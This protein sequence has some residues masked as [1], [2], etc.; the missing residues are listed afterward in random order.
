VNADYLLFAYRRSDLAKNDPST[1]I[2]VEWTTDLAG[3]WTDAVGTPGVVIEELND[4]ADAGVDLVK[5][6]IPRAPGGN[7]FARLAVAINTP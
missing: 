6:Y 1:T 3:A 5:V 4:S 7:L 2:K